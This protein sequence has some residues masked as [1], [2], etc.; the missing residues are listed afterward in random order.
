MKLRFIDTKS[1]LNYFKYYLYKVVKFI[2]WKIGIKLNHSSIRIFSFINDYNIYIQKLSD[3]SFLITARYHSL[4]IA[5]KTIT[6][7]LALKSN[8]FKIEGILEDIGIGQ[9]RIIG[10]NQI[11]TTPKIKFQKDEIKK[12]I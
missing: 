6:P 5:I 12:I 8:S 11:S 7:F 9:N 4:C 2:L 10:V 3:L 1:L